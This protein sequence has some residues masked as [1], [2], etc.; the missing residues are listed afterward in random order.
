M[1]PEWMSY[2]HAAQ[3]A[4]QGQDSGASELAIEKRLQF[5]E[6]AKD[7]TTPV[8]AGTLKSEVDP[9]RDPLLFPPLIDEV[10]LLLPELWREELGLS[11]VLD[12]LEKL[13]DAISG[14]TSSMHKLQL[15]DA[16]H[17]QGVA[18]DFRQG[19]GMAG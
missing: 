11:E 16:L 14:V 7:F 3:A 9:D 13:G 10:D 18:E 15:E 12:H 6:Q 4:S 17:Y 1:V 2:F 5:L 19:Q 8:K